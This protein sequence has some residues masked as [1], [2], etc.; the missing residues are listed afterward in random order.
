MAEVALDKLRRVFA[1]GVV[2]VDSVDLCVEHGELL[3]LLG[4]SGS[5]KS[6]LLRLIAGLDAP[7]SGEVRI[8]KR[9]VAH[10]RPWRRDVAM[11]LQRPTL[12]AHWTVRENLA[13][14]LE[15]QSTW[16]RLRRWVRRGAENNRHT[17]NGG[18]SDPVEPDSLEDRHRQLAWAAERMHIAHLLDRKPGELSGGEQQR[19]ALAR[20]AARRPAVFLLDEPLSNLDAPLRQKLREE[21]RLLQQRLDATMIYVTHDQAEAFALADRIAVMREGRIEQLGSPSEIYDQPATP[22]VAELVGIPAGNLLKGEWKLNAAEKTFCW[23]D[24][25]WNL[26]GGETQPLVEHGRSVICGIRPEDVHVGAAGQIPAIVLH[27][28]M[29]GR[30]Q[31]VR[32]KSVGAGEQH[33]AST[34]AAVDRPGDD[35]DAITAIAP[36]E[37]PVSAGDRVGLEF[38]AGACHWFDAESGQRLGGE[39]AEH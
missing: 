33:A 28:A 2:A 7:T 29:L 1:R 5:G 24:G 14:G 36:R 25:A 23:A 20:A 6:T 21:I 18:S 27:V 26:P 9:P 34:T 16:E 19:V 39:P 15:R 31:Q 35:R 4:P 12:Y 11:L 17:N 37:Q 22:S 13:F 8:G 30:V 38:A 3:V 32:L 10:L